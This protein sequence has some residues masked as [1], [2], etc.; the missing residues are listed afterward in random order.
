MQLTFVMQTARKQLHGLKLSI[1][2]I[3]QQSSPGLTNKLLKEVYKGKPAGQSP[4]NQ[5]K[6]G[7]SYKLPRADHEIRVP[8]S[9]KSRASRITYQTIHSLVNRRGAITYLTAAGTM[10]VPSPPAKLGRTPT[11]TLPALNSDRV[12]HPSTMASNT[13][14]HLRRSGACAIAGR[15]H[16][17]E[18]PRR[19]SDH[20]H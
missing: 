16:P 13:P 18:Q 7:I 2:R 5:K 3:Q 14:T 15:N 10:P 1:S 4:S 11:L 19:G 17:R 8:R 6:E 20:T 12:A 9:R